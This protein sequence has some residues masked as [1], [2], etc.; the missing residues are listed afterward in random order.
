MDGDS[1]KVLI[2]SPHLD[3]P[4]GAGKGTQRTGTLSPLRAH[5]HR[6]VKNLAE[7]HRREGNEV[8]VCEDYM[9]NFKIGNIPRPG[10]WD[11]IY[12]PHKTREQF[13]STHPGLRFWMQTVFPHLFTVDCDGWGASHSK[14]P[15]DHLPLEAAE[16]WMQMKHWTDLC[17]RMM[18]NESKFDQPKTYTS[19]LKADGFLFFPCQL[20]HDETIKFHSEFEVID[21]LRAVCDYATAKKLKLLVKGHPINPGSMAPLR[22]LV[23][24]YDRNYVEWSD[25]YSIHDYLANARTVFTVNSGVGFEALLHNKPVVTFGRCEYDE[26]TQ[27]LTPDTVDQVDL[28]MKCSYSHKAFTEEFVEKY[29]VDSS[30]I[31]SF[32]INK[33]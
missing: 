8:V 2:L 1:M 5:W 3:A 12:V 6:F 4:F 27:R 14:Y 9:W 32:R 15:F 31:N 33:V 7:F 18:K 28:D 19:D 17:V 24:T 13:G 29:C 16:D 11:R 30:K 22:G 25:E 23:E 20:P 26:V 10:Q 21:C